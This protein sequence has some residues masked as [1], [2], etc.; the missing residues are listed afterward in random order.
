L[1]SGSE[2]TGSQGLYLLR[3]SDFGARV[4]DFLSS[5]LQLLGEVSKLQYLSFKEG[6]PLLSHSAVD[7]GLVGL[8]ILEETL[9]KGIERGLR[10]L[11]RSRA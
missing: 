4:D 7:N 8:P 1:S 9:S 11:T 5:L 6:I 10:T 2:G 3:M